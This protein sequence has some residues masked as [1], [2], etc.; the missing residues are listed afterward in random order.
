MSA[1][2]VEE[3]LERVIECSSPRATVHGPLLS[4]VGCIVSA[5]VQSPTN[6][7]PFHQSAV[8]GYAFKA[9]SINETHIS[10]VGSSVA[11]MPY[12]GSVGDGSCV[13]IL[14]GAELPAG[15][16]TV[17]MQEDVTCTIGSIV[18]DPDNIEQ[19]SNVRK[20][21]SQCKEGEVILKAGSKLTPAAIGLLASVGISEV[22]CIAPP[23]IGI[24][25]TGNELTQP[26]E[27]LAPGAIYDSNGYMLTA[28]LLEGRIE[29]AFVVHVKDDESAIS[30][31][32]QEALMN[33]DVLLV[34]GGVS[35]GDYDYVPTALSSLGVSKQFHKVMQRP[36]KPLFFGTHEGGIVFGLPGNPASV[37]TCFYEYV[38]PCIRTLSGMTPVGFRSSMAPIL[39]SVKTKLGLK[40]FLK[41]RLGPRGVEPLPDQESYK[42]T[43]FAD[44]N[45]LIVIEAEDTEVN[46]GTVVSVHELV[47][48]WS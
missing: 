12:V 21:G 7:P 27:P 37:L 3:A 23:S 31:T 25:I 42:L 14:T 19:G 13:R 41:G 45:C 47:D 17:I 24:V 26:P 28:A 5:D 20:R 15:T 29:P 16:D 33:C 40:T 8:D 48:L 44:A 36:G 34:T 6:S 22:T 9:T 18:L 11:G 35:V 10:I 30:S 39:G 32:L 46:A 4:L 38:V 43:S 2:R 1:V